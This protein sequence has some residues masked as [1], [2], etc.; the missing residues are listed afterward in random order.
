MQPGITLRQ[1]QSDDGPKVAALGEQTPDTGVVAFR[2]H[3][4]YDPYASTMALHR[5]ATGV[6]VEASDHD[7]I[8]GMGMMSTGECQYNDILR[9]FAYL[10]SLS[11]HPDYRRQGIASQIAAWRID[12]ARKMLGD[13]A[14]IFAGIQKGNEGS[15]RNAAKWSTQRIDGRTTAGVVK[16]RSSPP[17]LLPGLE[18]R[19]AE[20]NDYEEIVH[21]QQDFYRDFNLYPPRDAETLYEWHSAAPFGFALREYYVVVDQEGNILAGLSATEEGKVTTGHVVR[22]SWPLRIVNLLVRMIPAIGVTKRIHLKDVWFAPEKLEVGKYLWESMRWLWRT[23]GTMMMS[24]YDIQSPLAQVIQ[25][26]S[27]MPRQSGSLVVTGPTPMREE[28]Y[29]YLHT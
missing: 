19:P 22:L 28:Q 25:A 3:F 5:N 23:R 14:V 4:L 1:I 10:F 13:D 15:L 24:F 20:K 11:V 27:Y 7:G 26:P 17:R 12:K 9:P 18:V 8:V 29:I 2:N 6:V 16:M 21:K